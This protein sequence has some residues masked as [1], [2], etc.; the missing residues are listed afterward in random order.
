MI[1]S[2]FFSVPKQNMSHL[3]QAATKRIAGDTRINE[4]ASEGHGAKYKA[5]KVVWAIDVG[6]VVYTCSPFHSGMPTNIIRTTDGG[7]H[8]HAQRTFHNVSFF[9]RDILYYNSTF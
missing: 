1:H 9:A 7:D 2:A 3:Q 8:I 6:D 4:E 5:G